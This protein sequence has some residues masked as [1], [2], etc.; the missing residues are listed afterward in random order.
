MEIAVIGM[1]GKFP[2]ANNINEF[3]ENLQKGVEAIHFSSEEELKHARL[4]DGVINNPDFVKARGVLADVEYFDAHFFGYTPKEAELMNP[5][6]RI[7][8]ECAWE[9]LE[10]GGYDPG[11]YKGLIGLYAGAA[12]SFHWE[13]LVHLSGKTADVGEFSA[14]HLSGKDSLVSRVSYKLGLKGPGVFIHTACSTGLL[15]IHMASRVLLTGECDMALAG[16]VGILTDRTAGYF[17]QQGMILSP[18]GHCR[19]FAAEANGTIGGEGVGVVLL[20]P[21]QDALD[22]RDYIYAVIKGSAANNDGQRKVGYTAPSIEGQAEVIRTALGIAR[23]PP[24]TIGYIETHGTGTNLGDPIEISALKLA[25]KTD[26][27]N[28]CPIGSVKTNIGHLDTAAGIAGFIKTILILRH[29][30]ITPTLHFHRPN[31]EIDFTNSPFYVNTALKQWKSR[32]Y[33]FRAGVS[34]FGIGGTNVHTVLE[35]WPAPSQSSPSGQYQLILLSAKTETALNKMTGNLAGYLKKNPLTNLS[36]VA[37]T[38]QVGRKA[39]AHRRMLVC[40]GLEEV[41]AELTAPDSGKVRTTVLKEKP[42]SVIFMFPGLGAQYVNMGRGL[43]QTEPV[44]REE[45]NHCFEIL[46]PLLNDD[47]KE[48]LYPGIPVNFNRSDRLNR[49]NRPYPSYIHRTEIAQVVVFILEYALARLLLKWGIVPDSMIGY[50]LGEYTAACISGVFSLEEALKIVVIRGRLIQRTSPGRMLS[51]PLPREELQPLLN[52][53]LSIAIDNGPTCI[54]SGPA[55]PMET[56]EKQMKEKRL[57]CM[58][59]S[60]AHGLHSQMMGPILQEYERAVGSITLK[61]PRIPF[62]SNVTGNWITMED[63][64]SPRY[65]AR[66]LRET[67]YFAHGI[68]KLTGQLNSILVEVGPGRDLSALLARHLGEHQ[69]QAA[70]NLVKPQEKDTPDLYYLLDKIGRLWLYGVEGDWHEFYS[71]EKRNRIPI[72]VYPFER[73]RYWIDNRYGNTGRARYLAKKEDIT[74]W[75]YIPSWKSTRQPAGHR[76]PPHSPQT[77]PYLVFIDESGLG[78]L[79][80]EKLKPYGRGIITVKQG[81][82]YTRISPS[83]YEIN[84]VSQEDFSNLWQ[85]L[86]KIKTMPR[87]ILYFWAISLQETE[88]PQETLSLDQLDKFIQLGFNSL[89]YL[90]QAMGKL[91][92]NKEHRFK[93]TIITNKMHSTRGEGVSYPGFALVMGPLKV[94]PLEYPGIK[95]RGIDIAFEKGMSGIWSGARLIDRLAAEVMAEFHE[96]VIAYRGSERLVPTYEPVPL[97]KLTETSPLLKKRGVYLILGGTGGIGLELAGYLAKFLQARL[98]LLGRS[99]FPPREQWHDILAAAGENDTTASKIKKIKTFE[100]WGVEVMLAEADVTRPGQMEAVINRIYQRFGQ[101]NGVIHCAGIPDSSLIQRKT[102]GMMKKELAAK[103]RGTVVLNNILKDRELDFFLL[104]SSANAIIPHLGQVGYCAANCFLDAFAH[105]NTSVHG[106]FTISVNWDRWQGTGIARIAEARHEQITEAE[107]AGGITPAEGIDIFGR[108]MENTYPQLIISVHDIK[109]GV[110]RFNHS[111]IRRTRQL[112]GDIAPAAPVK[113]LSRRPPVSTNYAPPGDETQQILAGIWQA[114]FGIEPLGIHDDFFELGGDSLKAITAIARTHNQLNVE[115]SLNEFFNRPTIHQ[116]AEYIRSAGR[117]TFL[118][119]EPVEKKEYYHA[120]SAQRRLFT[121][122]TLEGETS[123]NFNIFKTVLIKGNLDKKRMEESFKKLIR[124]HES[125]RTSFHVINGNIRQVVHRCDEI[126]FV[127]EYLSCQEE[128]AGNHINRFIMTPFDLAKAPLLKVELLNTGP[129]RHI[130]SASTHHIAADGISM[131]L[132]VND[133]MGLYEKK[134]FAPLKLQYRD[135]AQWQN[136]FL[137]R[138]KPGKQEAYWLDRFKG[139]I[140]VLDIPTDYPRPALRSTA[141]NIIN[142]S[143]SKALLSGIRRL[144]NE[145]GTTLYMAF[146]AALYIMLSKYTLQEEDIVIGS[147]VS[148]RNH[149]NLLNIIGTFANMLAM[150]NSPRRDKTF[151][152]FLAEVKQNALA[153]YENQDY[154]FEQLVTKL[155]IHPNAGRN[156][157]FDVVLNVFSIESKN[158]DNERRNNHKPTPGMG[159]SFQPYRGERTSASYDLLFRVLESADT[160]NLYLEYSTVLFKPTTT[161]KILKHYGEVLEQVVEKTTAP[162]KEFSLSQEKFLLVKDIKQQEDVGFDF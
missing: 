121:L 88:T 104:C 30:L 84:P 33:P 75:F 124:R 57:M 112:P 159:L 60:A 92:K 77:S 5:Q 39:F 69:N 160:V 149:V 66:H 128:K 19:A 6:L 25:F 72:P 43:Y 117:D 125:L 156:P 153:A 56:F 26:R 35:E 138:E 63:A 139:K 116:L 145:T 83:E 127:L 103:V 52:P 20:K 134:E 115:I 3:W 122:V 51:V 108:I 113:Q 47:I 2:A 32:G 144:T 68:K 91:G 107:L 109:A 13:G 14:R 143:L 102:P 119:I 21:L 70:V 82:H 74:D 155:G 40:T 37:Y 53:Q 129:D 150:K 142:Y 49:S 120:S 94:I 4:D 41:A 42:K 151:K 15:A 50:S 79:V 7:F 46:K 36:D 106:K 126:T 132:L 137:P 110:D 98:I 136:R 45:M 27:Q 87:E 135:Y 23:T 101:I 90:V 123:V 65:W 96:S 152:E 62:I 67:V 85:E 141:G 17:Y 162:L 64:L 10:D 71:Q 114:L 131:D 1:S 100:D 105:Y 18:D 89:L 11:A 61:K 29:R 55:A 99:P 22:D 157:L 146:L 95:T 161:E 133:F 154:Q 158:P 28:F 147:P 81:K 148:G 24:E 73:Q 140:P 58:R 80:I 34:S 86:F 48:I 38:L 93:L 9:A 76:H 12:A 54:V 31:P 97:E 44:F 16:A 118:S 130:L 8:H 59:L 78:T 111:I